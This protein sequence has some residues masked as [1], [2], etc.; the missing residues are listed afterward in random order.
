[1]LKELGKIVIIRVGSCS[2]CTSR[3]NL[4]P[5]INLKVAQ[6]SLVF[7]CVGGTGHYLQNVSM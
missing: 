5:G 6:Y 1:M 4:F 7:V 2:P 3:L